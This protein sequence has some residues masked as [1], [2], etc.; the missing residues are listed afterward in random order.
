MDDRVDIR[1]DGWTL[2]RRSGELVR[3]GRRLRLQTQP[4]QV[5][6]ALLEQPGELV[7]REQLRARL[8]PKGV[9]D[10]DTALNSAV[11]R[12]RVALDD[13][14]DQPRYI[15]TVPRRGYRYIGP[16]D[17]PEAASIRIA[18]T[19]PDPASVADSS[20]R[21]RVARW[22]LL[23]AVL[24]AVI[25]AGALSAWRRAGPAGSVA[26]GSIAAA[27]SPAP[28]AAQERLLRAEHFLKR[29]DPGDLAL[30]LRYFREAVEIEPGL[31]RAWTGM[32]AAYWLLMVEGELAPEQ[33]LEQLRA[34]AERAI[35]LEPSHAEPQLRLALYYFATGDSRRHAEY[36]DRALALEPGNP[37]V[38][39]VSASRAAAEGDLAA[40]IRLQQRAVEADPLSAVHRYNLASWFYLAGRFDEA[41][42]EVRRLLEMHPDASRF[43]DLLGFVLLLRGQHAEALQLAAGWPAGR[44]R[45]FVEAL[46][47]HGLGL[48]GEAEASMRAL[49]EA[50]GDDPWLL[51]EAHAF[52]GEH[53]QAFAALQAGARQPGRLPWQGRG[54]HVRWLVPLSP[55]LQPLKEDPRWQGWRETLDAG[56]QDRR[57]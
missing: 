7:T 53:D 2:L 42:A 52:R 39:S 49:V 45:R 30:A 6:E 1:F 17:A 31:A 22:S 38:L 44:E 13:H 4:L 34:A 40:A 48:H 27:T 18:G 5:L 32:A 41:A 15:E 26:A 37:L 55:F 24:A 29:R 9:V 33:G 16:L 11:H 8:W 46:A 23:A 54:R 35:E 20:R 10:F 28:S 36:V 12:L 57:G 51:A 47:Q 25:A 3:D 56:Q 21:G 14:A 43:A 19:V 50:H